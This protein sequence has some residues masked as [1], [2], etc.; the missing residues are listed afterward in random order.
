MLAGSWSPGRQRCSCCCLMSASLTCV[1]P[2]GRQRGC[3][4]GCLLVQ[5][6]HAGW[7]T[8]SSVAVAIN[9]GCSGARSG[10]MVSL[11]PT[12]WTERQTRSWP[13]SPAQAHT[14]LQLR[15]INYSTAQRVSKAREGSTTG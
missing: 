11:V 1:G 14:Y 8:S 15:Q 3:G 2:Q 5:P 9:R 6:I 10:A 12:P 7:P 4:A 13:C